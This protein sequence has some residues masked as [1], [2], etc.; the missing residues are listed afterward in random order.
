MAQ[1]AA[2]HHLGMAETKQNQ[3][4]LAHTEDFVFPSHMGVRQRAGL[5]LCSSVSP[6]YE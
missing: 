1:E 6:E 5:A 4:L 2:S 3:T